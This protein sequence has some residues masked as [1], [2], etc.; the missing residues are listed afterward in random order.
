MLWQEALIN[1]YMETHIPY[2]AYQS[3]ILNIDYDTIESVLVVCAI[4]TSLIESVLVVCG[5]DEHFS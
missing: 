1:S 3:A 5:T 4:S 2:Y